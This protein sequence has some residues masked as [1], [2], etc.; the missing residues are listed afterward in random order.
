MAEITEVFSSRKAA[1]DDEA[2]SRSAVALT[3]LRLPGWRRLVLGLSV[4]GA[5][6]I[7]AATYS[8]TTA[9]ELERARVAA[10]LEAG[11]LAE[12]LA[13]EQKRLAPVAAALRVLLSQEAGGSDAEDDPGIGARLEGVLMTVG[14]GGE[15]QTVALV[16]PGG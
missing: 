12:V 2:A 7:L 8:I 5:I 10:G 6:L 4:M 15:P 9:R 11:M 16:P 3:M 14:T 1:E 13:D